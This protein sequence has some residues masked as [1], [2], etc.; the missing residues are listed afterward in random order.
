M[1][2]VSLNEIVKTYSNVTALDHVSIAIEEGEIHALLGENGAGKSTL[3]KVLYGMTQ[4]DSGEII[5]DGKKQDIC[6]P[7]QAIQLGIGMVHQHFML[8]GAMNVVENVIAGAE[9]R[10]GKVVD[11]HRAEKEIRN[12]IDKFGFSVSL[13]SLIDELTVGEKQQ[14]EILKILYRSAEVLILD[15]PT[16][17]LTPQETENFFRILRKMKENGKS[18]II[19]TH[20]LYEVFQIADRVTIMRNGIVTGHIEKDQMKHISVDQL[21]E[22]MVGD[23]AWN[24]EKIENNVIGD[25]RFEAE[26][27]RYEKAGKL[28]LDN[29]SFKIHSGEIFGIAGVEGNGQSE[30]VKVL[31]GLIKPDAMTLKLDGKEIQGSVKD[32]IKSGIGHIPEDRLKYAV[33]ENMTIAENLILGY[34][35]KTEFFKHGIMRLSEIRNM[36]EKRIEKYHIKTSGADDLISQLSGG[37]QQKVVVARVFE[38]MSKVLICSQLTRGVDISTSQFFYSLLRKFQKEGNSVLL[39][40]SD[41]QEI[42]KLSDTIAVMFKGK[43]VGIRKKK[44]F[45]VE[46][47]GIL[48]TGGTLEDEKVGEYD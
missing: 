43:I 19:I 29:V 48:M 45:T 38:E 41:L 47:I 9:P 22:Y 26:N 1:S 14:V 20:K 25:V 36:A 10:K 37:N 39:V 27:L 24:E 30:L 34:Q 21:V 23:N 42:F 6:N 17:V 40:S 3:M 5:V 15:E 32:F 13:H 46:E 28:I 44:D 18:C 7:M 16:A 4:P 11:Y 2:T 8:A 35:D 31:T 33:A 12:M